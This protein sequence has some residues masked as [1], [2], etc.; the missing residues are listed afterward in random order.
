MHKELKKDQSIPPKD[1]VREHRRRNRT[2]AWV[3]CL[4]ICALM[5]AKVVC[6]VCLSMALVRETDLTQFLFMSVREQAR[7]EQFQDEQYC[8]IKCPDQNAMNFAKF[9]C[10]HNQNRL[11]SRIDQIKVGHLTCI[12][13]L[14]SSAMAL[15]LLG[16]LEYAL[17]RRFARREV[18]HLCWSGTKTIDKVHLGACALPLFLLLIVRLFFLIMGGRSGYE[19]IRKSQIR[20]EEEWRSRGDVDIQYFEAMR[21]YLLDVERASCPAL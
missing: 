20:T 14:F 2:L 1:L 16:F 4:S 17:K 10:L 3:S 11:F 13:V 7:Y 9:L 18:P 19:M 21:N 15:M 6:V 8:K 5:V 12:Q